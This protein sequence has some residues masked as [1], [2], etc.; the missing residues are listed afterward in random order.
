MSV[1]ASRWLCCA[2]AASPPPRVS[3]RP[4]AAGSGVAPGLEAAAQFPIL[5]R[6]IRSRR[7]IYL[8]N[9]ASSQKPQAVLDA[10]SAYYAQVNSNVHR[11]VH[12]LAAEATDAYERARVQVGDE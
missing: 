8:D 10:M 5:Q 4:A 7:L 2:S 6:E 12:T 11:G 3:A 9:A 1:Q